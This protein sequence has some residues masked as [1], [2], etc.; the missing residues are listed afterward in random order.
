MENT[1]FDDIRAYYDDEIPVA[2]QRI[3]DDPL[4]E[5]AAGFAFPGMD[6]E[7]V[8][9]AIR[10]CRTT[11]QIQ[12][13]IMYPAIKRIIDTTIAEFTASGI[14]NVS[15]DDGQLFISNHRDIVL[16]AFMLQFALFTRS[17]PTT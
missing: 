3:A 15:P 2:M 6:I 10:A 4:L 1:S 16:D 13:E 11:D 8:R 5:P 14:E 9:A 17:L 7:A 12:R